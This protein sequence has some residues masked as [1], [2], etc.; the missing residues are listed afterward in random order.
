MLGEFPPT[1]AS[2]SRLS[3]FY[4]GCIFSQNVKLMTRLKLTISDELMS[5]VSASAERLWPGE[6]LRALARFVRDAI[7]RYVRYCNGRVRDRTRK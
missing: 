4:T 2:Y 1:V 7:R 5:V 3:L 6:G